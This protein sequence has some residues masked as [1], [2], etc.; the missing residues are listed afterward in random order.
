MLFRSMLALALVASMACSSDNVGNQRT[1]LG[2]TVGVN[3]HY[4]SYGPVN[5]EALA[6]LANAGVSFVRNDLTWDSVEK[7]AGVYDFVGS[8][9]DELVDRC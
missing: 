6:R 3:T 4:G 1:T 9:Y 8:G 2:Q 7:E 5:H